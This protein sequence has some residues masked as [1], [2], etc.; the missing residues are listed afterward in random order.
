MKKLIAIVAL[1]TTLL[2]CG[3]SLTYSNGD[4][5][6]KAV[7]VTT[8]VLI[9]GALLCS[10]YCEVN[11]KVNDVNVVGGN[12]DVN[13]SGKFEAPTKEQVDEAYN[14][15]KEAEANYSNSN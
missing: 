10:E 15:W 1:S 13:V 8:G 6:W 4:V 2:G 3:T 7:A 14:A 9:A 11:H 5:N 12:I